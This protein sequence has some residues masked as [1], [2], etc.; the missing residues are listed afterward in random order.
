MYFFFFQAEDGIRDGRVT[1]VQ[2]CALPIWRSARAA[3]SARSAARSETSSACT[4]PYGRGP[5]GRLRILLVSQMYPG[6]A[7]PDLGTFVR[8]LE[9]ALRERGHELELAVLDRRAGGKRRYAGLA[10]RARA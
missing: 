10:V 3:R 4:T 8:Q 2:T 5:D 6:P 9:L 1:G 7:D